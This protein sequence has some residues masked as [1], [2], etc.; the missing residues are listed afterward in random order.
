M[1]DPSK[2]VLCKS[3]IDIPMKKCE[4]KPP[5]NMS[6]E[7]L[8]LLF[9]EPDTKKKEGIRDLA[10]MTLLYDTGARVSELIGLKIED[11][12]MD[13]STATVR[14]LGKGRKQ[15]IVPI[16]SATADIMKVYYK[17]NKI[18]INNPHR[19]VFMNNRGETLTRPGI[20]YILD[21]YIRRIRQHNPDK[22]RFKITAHTMRHSKATILLLSDVNL[23][24]IRDFLGHAS[25][26][27]TE[28]YAKTNPEFLRRAVEKNARNYNDALGEYAQEEKECLSEFL[29][30][31]R[32]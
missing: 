16:S 8:K 5:V 10:I 29:K 17:S 24:Y 32:K 20:N 21:K 27:T 7:E 6:E 22:Y 13:K 19:A 14:I 4:K 30:N 26:V 31:F 9:A 23:V 18:D 12:R 11:I 28:V 3:I 15:M 1:Q 2:L 25:V